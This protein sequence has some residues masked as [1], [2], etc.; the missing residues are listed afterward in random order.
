L[1]PD[2]KLFHHVGVSLALMCQEEGN[3][4]LKFA[5]DESKIRRA[6]EEEE[7]LFRSFSLTLSRLVP[8][9]TLG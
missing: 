6:A 4:P 8:N 1:L 9:Q 2:E 5:A 7:N 3:L